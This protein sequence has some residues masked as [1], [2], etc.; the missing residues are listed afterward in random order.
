MSTHCPHCGAE[1][2]PRS[3][4]CLACGAP[5]AGARFGADETGPTATVPG[6]GSI[7][8]RFRREQLVPASRA[9][10]QPVAA[11]AVILVVGALALVGLRELMSGSRER[12]REPVVSVRPGD[13]QIPSGVTASPPPQPR[14]QPPMSPLTT[15]PPQ[16]PNAPPLPTAPLLSAPRPR[17]VL[18]EAP[19][20]AP[21]NF[22]PS[23][24]PP[25]TA[26]LP[27]I[28]PAAPPVAVAPNQPPPPAPVPVTPPQPSRAEPPMPH[29]PPPR[30]EIR[31]Y[32]EWLRRAEFYR[33]WLY[34]QV[35]G[36]RLE[37]DATDVQR[38]LAALLDENSVVNPSAD[39]GFLRYK[40]ATLEQARLAA[41]RLQTETMR[42]RPP[43]ACL[44]LHQLFAQAVAR[45]PQQ[46]QLIQER[47]I[48]QAQGAGGAAIGREWLVNTL[49]RNL[50]EALRAADEELARV[51]AAHGLPKDF[52]L[53]AER[54][55]MGI[56]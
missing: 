42:V 49:D 40:L 46:L 55:W 33:A 11:A 28:R 32:L 20:L 4:F 53:G 3:K 26:L 48:M 10:W 18:P 23:T 45:M 21:G 16:A 44:R 29:A 56:R 1:V 30:E 12:S 25:L 34:G 7:T 50:L 36:L 8:R 47:Q 5:L 6:K 13:P 39:I 17:E 37:M 27:P 24:G 54:G 14:S 19:I 22:K 43:A 38:L 31:W 9:T 2:P 41:A 52:A 51:T 35:V 15:P